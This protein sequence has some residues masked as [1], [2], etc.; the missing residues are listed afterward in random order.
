MAEKEIAPIDL[1]SCRPGK[2]DTMQMAVYRQTESSTGPMSVLAD[3]RWLLR[4]SKETQSTKN[5]RSNE[6]DRERRIDR[7]HSSKKA[8]VVVA[9]ETMVEAGESMESSLIRNILYS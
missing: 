4:F 8:T 6:S 1:V 2:E 5:I 3:F 7:S 9:G